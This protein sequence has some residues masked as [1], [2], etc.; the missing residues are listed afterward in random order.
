MGNYQNTKD[1]EMFGSSLLQ[2]KPHLKK[3]CNNVGFNMLSLLQWGG[4]FMFTL[5]LLTSNILV[6]ITKKISEFIF[7]GDAINCLPL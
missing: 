6:Y 2:Y 1:Y 5:L 3:I 4:C 7:V